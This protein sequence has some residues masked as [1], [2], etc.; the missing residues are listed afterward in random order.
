MEEP[1]SGVALPENLP[2]LTNYVLLQNERVW[3]A[4]ICVIPVKFGPNETYSRTGTASKPSMDGSTRA[5]AISI[6]TDL[7]DDAP[8][9]RG[10]A[11]SRS[12]VRPASGSSAGVRG[13]AITTTDQSGWTYSGSLARSL[14]P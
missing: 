8:S 10:V 12:R 11:T 4:S 1:N 5:A 9:A 13:G 7:L 2:W 14:R 6:T 3:A